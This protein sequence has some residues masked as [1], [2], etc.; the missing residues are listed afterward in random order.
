MLPR[1]YPQR[2]SIS[3]G[4]SL[5]E[6]LVAFTVLAL[7]L[8]AVLQVVAS[9]LR[10]AGAGEE[11]T[12]ATLLAQSKLAEFSVTEQLPEGVEEGSFDDRFDWR[13]T[14]APYLFAQEP[15][16]TQEIDRLAVTPVT[17]TVEVSWEQGVRRHSV[18]LTTLQ[19]SSR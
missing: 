13:L 7:V 18:E 16:G 4:F 15:A 6:V 8:G 19:L 12:R 11:Y 3:A 2:A 10:A 5:L 9:G 14:V 17:V 1:R